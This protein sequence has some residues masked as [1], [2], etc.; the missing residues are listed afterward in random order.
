MLLG[1]LSAVTALLTA[2][3]SSSPGPSPLGDGGTPGTQ[4]T[5]QS[6]G[7]PVTLGLYTLD[8]R[9]TL[10]VVISSVSLPKS[11]RGLRMTKAWLVPI[12]HD[13]KNGDWDVIGVGWPY[14]PTTQPNWPRRRP[15]PGAVIKP[16]QDLNLVFGLIRT[17]NSAG[18]SPGPEVT[19]TAKGNIYTLSEQTGLVV[20]AK[21]F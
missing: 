1:A 14:P 15:A 17:T 19:Y 3:C 7:Q 18:R 11:A 16:G 10:P 4:C 21:C 6:G 9:S 20:A 2:A 5:R 8:N 12:Y 13:L